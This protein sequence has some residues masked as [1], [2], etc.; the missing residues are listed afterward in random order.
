M[1]TQTTAPKR[2]RTSGFSR[3]ETF[4]LR[5][6]W[7][8]KGLNAISGGIVNF[9]DPGA[10][11]EMG[12]GINMLRSLGYWMRATQLADFTGVPKGEGL[13]F[14]LTEIGRLISENDPYL[15]DLGT[16][17]VLQYELASNKSLAPLWYWVF[18]L[19]RTREF[20]DE[21]MSQGF[22]RFLAEE[23]LPK[24]AKETV[25]RDIKCFKRTYSP[26]TR[27]ERTGY[28]EDLMDCPLAE[29]GLIRESATPGNYSLKF[30]PHSGLPALVFAYA[31]L[32]YRETYA[33]D[34][35]TISLDD[36]RWAPGSP[37][38]MFCLDSGTTMDLLEIL[39]RDTNLV[40]I[41]RSE[42]ISQVRIS[43]DVS[44]AQ[45]LNQYFRNSETI[46]I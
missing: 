14:E 28:H 21:S 42:G 18:N 11:H 22:I 13:P 27:T 39:E 15:E 30:G 36:L 24:Y 45:V 20:T 33:V 12:V 4:H 38:R 17:W 16:L 26:S 6:S 35:S 2:P 23:N 40:G 46:S 37:G 3:H 29:L 31:L 19:M 9:D 41:T 34:Q 44:A 32:R 10:H 7:I 25:A 43:D 8:A 5:Y 1:T